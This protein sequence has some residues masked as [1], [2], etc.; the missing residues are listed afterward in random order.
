M[1]YYRI[2]ATQANYTNTTLPKSFELGTEN[3]VKIWVANNGAKHIN[4]LFDSWKKS[5]YQ[6]KMVN[7]MIQQILRGLQSTVNSATHNGVIYDQL[8]TVFGAPYFFP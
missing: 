6:P 5:G 2:V 8:M 4:K 7:I 3:G 1:W